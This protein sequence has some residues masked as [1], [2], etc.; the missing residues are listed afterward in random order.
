[1]T[2]RE[3]L[4]RTLNHEPV[5]RVPRDLWHSPGV[6][7]FRAEEVAEIE[8]RYPQDIV[9]PDFEY[10]RGKRSKGKP[11]RVGR[12]TDAWGCTW[13]VTERGTVGEVEDPPLA[14]PAKTAEYRPPFEL[15]AT[16]RSAQARFA[17]ANRS[18]AATSRFVLAWTATRPFDRLQLLRGRDAA[19]DDLASGNQQIRSLLAMLHDFSCREMEMWAGTDVDGVA[20]RDDWGTPEGLLLAPEIWRD[21]FKPLYRDYCKILHGKDK[22]V[23]FHS[24]GKIPEIFGE[25][26]RVGF[27]AIHCQLF[28]MD[29]ERLAKRYRGRVTFWG[30]IDSL[31]VLP[32][33]TTEEI[34]QAVRRVRK[35]LDFG[36]GGVIAQCR[37]PLNVPLRNI[38]VVFEQWM[39]PLPMHV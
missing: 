35:A 26:V 38:A 7:L 3:L 8:L 2:S 19:L 10:P 5:D 33:G 29:I 13:R 11:Y 31:R 23:F 27:D 4:I 18:C 25:L 37:W 30:E 15:L 34:R 12:Y 32:F 21:L 20:L 6:E 36:S 39:M 1:M 9:Q 16:D 17:R 28:L 14:D 22:F 24:D